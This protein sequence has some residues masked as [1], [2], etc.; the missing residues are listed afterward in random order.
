MDDMQNQEVCHAQNEFVSTNLKCIENEFH[1]LS[2]YPLYETERTKLYNQI[3][4]I[5]DNF[6]SL[7][8][9]DKAKWL[10]LQEEQASGVRPSVRSSSVNIIK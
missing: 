6:I 3:H 8:D 5:N 4:H 9:N 1:F 7:S 2:R 10:L